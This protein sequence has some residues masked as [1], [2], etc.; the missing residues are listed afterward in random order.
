MGNNAS[1]NSQ[2]GQHLSSQSNNSNQTNQSIS[3]KKLNSK[4]SNNQIRKSTAGNNQNNSL[5]EEF[6]D[7][8]LHQVINKPINTTNEGE[9]NN[10]QT[11][12]IQSNLNPIQPQNSN[13]QYNQFSNGL[14]EDEF[15]E[16]N[17]G[18]VEESTSLSRNILPDNNNY[19]YDEN[20]KINKNIPSSN[21]N[22][23]SSTSQYQQRSN[24]NDDQMELDEPFP[25]DSDDIQEFEYQLSQTPTPDLSK[26]DFT[27]IS[28][29]QN[30]STQQQQPQSQS[31][32]QQQQQQENNNQY[33]ANRPPP[34][35]RM[36]SAASIARSGHSPSPSPNLEQQQHQNQ[37]YQQNQQQQLHSQHYHNQSYLNNFNHNNNQNQHR[38]K[39]FKSNNHNDNLLIPIE[40]KWVNTNRENIGKISI[41]GSFSNWRDII[42][43]SPSINH[44][45]EFI[46]TIN[47]PLGVHKLLYIINNEYR[48]SDQLPTATDQE[49]IFFNWFEVI[50]DTHLFNHSLNQSNHIGASTDYDANIISSRN[51]VNN[52]DSTIGGYN[53]NSN[54][55]QNQPRSAGKYEFEKIQE[56]SNEL[57]HKISKES[58][59][60]FE[61]VEYIDDENN[62]NNQDD[63]LM[64]DE[65]E[66]ELKQKQIEQQKSD[67]YPYP[68]HNHNRSNS[69]QQTPIQS[70]HQFQ[71]YELTKSNSFI[72]PNQK[73]NYSN[74]I[75]EMFINYDYF[76]LKPEDYELPEPPQLPPHL[77]NVLLNKISNNQSSSSNSNIS[78]SN[79]LQNGPIPPQPNNPTSSTISTNSTSTTNTNYL[80]KRPPLR[81]AD[82]SYYASNK[83][84]YHLSIPN[85][86]I[87]NH[88]MTTSIKNDVLTVACITRY[89]GKFV[90]Q[91]MHSPADK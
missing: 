41:I 66:V 3:N 85:H 16:L 68:Q 13:Q 89:S 8:I 15:N 20:K 5:D 60:Q 81:R 34:T 33:F 4:N 42:K 24:T 82:S 36:L 83:E 17:E 19:F 67:N 30:Q 39:Q 43:L 84:A 61:H 54:T 40:I 26:V 25:Q 62:E 21:S 78:T 70:T 55:Y 29:Y 12:T 7:L 71:P 59:S 64:I 6:S 77:N 51:D 75:P 47:L 53:N 46:T 10:N 38:T 88:L 56:K 65:G 9:G 45:N 37:Q 2:F 22:S 11:S 79:L 1:T 91:I 49:G 90:T 69:Q 35:A 28:T 86:V 18:L 23:S 48:V 58:S 57:L 73:L 80:N 32:P 87:L 72:K 27:K 50:D 76:K 31:Q 44:P 14:I 52:S 74:E 63:N